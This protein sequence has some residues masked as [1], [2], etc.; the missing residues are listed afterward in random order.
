MNK[1]KLQRKVAMNENGYECNK[2]I[3]TS[4]SCPKQNNYRTTSKVSLNS[5]RGKNRSFASDFD[6]TV[7]P[8]TAPNPNVHL[9]PIDSDLSSERIIKPISGFDGYCGEWKEFADI[10]SKVFLCI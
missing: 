9:Q 7:L 5:N 3:P 1:S 2:L 4:L 6:I 10:I 8:I